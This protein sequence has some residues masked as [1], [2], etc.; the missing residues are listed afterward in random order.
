MNNRVWDLFDRFRGFVDVNTFFDLVAYALLLK[1]VELKKPYYYQDNYS[2]RYLS[3]L[4]GDIILESDLCRYIGEIEKDNNIPAGLLEQ[5]F[6]NIIRKFE[7]EREKQALLAFFRELSEI[8]FISENELSASFDYLLDKVPP[9]MGRMGGCES[10]TNIYLARLESAVL[11]VNEGQEI[12][13]PFCGSGISIVASG[14]KFNPLSVRDKNSDIV[15]IATINMILHGCKIREVTCGDSLF[16]EIRTYDRVVSEPP[17]NVKYPD[18]IYDRFKDNLTYTISRDSL[19]LELIINSLND[20][21]KAV[22][23]VPQGFFFRSGRSLEYRKHL[24][25][26]NIIDSIINLPAGVLYG[27]AISASLLLINKNKRNKDILMLDS[28]S[29]WDKRNL[30]ELILSDESINKIVEIISNREE[31]IGISKIVKYEEI[32]E[33]NFNLAPTFYVAPYTA[34][35]IEVKDVKGLITK[36]QELEEDLSKVSQKLYKMRHIE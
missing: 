4:Y 20:Y 2:I 29:L 10:F 34:D 15:A 3:R 1:Y 13:D 18:N 25:E 9:S 24:V 26:A 33:N 12:Y 16:A 36:Q 11:D 14:G 27:T 19:E 35:D 7:S 17:L 22:V 8:D 31:K 23:L 5:S 32:K 21:G 6:R 30:R 28:S